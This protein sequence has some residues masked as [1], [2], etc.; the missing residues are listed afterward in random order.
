MSPY[1]RSPLLGRPKVTSAADVS[2]IVDYRLRIPDG[3]RLTVNSERQEETSKRRN[4][5]T[6]KR[7]NVETRM[8]DS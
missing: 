3:L 8:A 4:V 5:E 6:S 2:L 7:R 1:F